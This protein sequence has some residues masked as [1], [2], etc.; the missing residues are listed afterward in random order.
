MIEIKVNGKDVTP[1]EAVDILFQQHSPN[2]YHIVMMWVGNMLNQI[3]DKAESGEYD[4]SQV[5][6][7]LHLT[8]EGM[9]EISERAKQ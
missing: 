1:E 6:F 9:N 2:Y 8:A 7:G 3:L 4:L 5:L